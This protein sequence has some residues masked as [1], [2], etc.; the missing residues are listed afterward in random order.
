MALKSKKGKKLYEKTKTDDPLFVKPSLQTKM[1][2]S[3]VEGEHLHDLDFFGGAGRAIIY[4]LNEL[5]DDMEEIR[6]FGTGSGEI[7]VD[8][9]SF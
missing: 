6:R 8:G 1:S 3:Y 7:N 9:G 5:N 2:Q 4:Q